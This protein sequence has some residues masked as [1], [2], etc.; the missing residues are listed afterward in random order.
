MCARRVGGGG[1]CIHIGPVCVLSVCVAATR[2]NLRLMYMTCNNIATKFHREVWIRRFQF[3]GVCHVVI[4]LCSGLYVCVRV[5]MFQ[6]G[7]KWFCHDL[8]FD[9]TLIYIK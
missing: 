6:G 2:V 8:L 5:R 3:V 7:P 1:V 9:A 4:L